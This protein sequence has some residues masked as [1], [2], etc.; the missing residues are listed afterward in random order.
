MCFQPGNEYLAISGLYWFS[1]INKNTCILRKTL[2]L[3]Q[4]GTLTKR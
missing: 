2:F 1:E 4:M 3:L